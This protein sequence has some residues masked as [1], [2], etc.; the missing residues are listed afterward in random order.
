MSLEMQCETE[1]IINGS[2]KIHYIYNIFVFF[3]ILSIIEYF[4][5]MLLGFKDVFCSFELKFISIGGL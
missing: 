4:L 5:L 1:V 3:S 2:I